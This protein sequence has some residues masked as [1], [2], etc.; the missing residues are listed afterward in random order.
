MAVASR[1]LDSNHMHWNARDIL[2]RILSSTSKLQ[3]QV[4]HIRREINDIAHSCAHQVLR[5]S[6]DAPI[7]CCSSSAHASSFCPA[8]SFL[9]NAEWTGFVILAVHCC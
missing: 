2:V 8:I 1:K 5:T 7:L 3:A 6:L 9:Q 4:F